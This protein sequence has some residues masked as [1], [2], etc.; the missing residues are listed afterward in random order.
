VTPHL[1]AQIAVAL[2]VLALAALAIG[3]PGA[4]HLAAAAIALGV[5][6]EVEMWER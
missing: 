3:A 1:A 6:A 5:E 2:F 4:W